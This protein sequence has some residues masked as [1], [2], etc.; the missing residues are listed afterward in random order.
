V[1]LVAAMPASVISTVVDKVKSLV[2]AGGPGG[3]GQIPQGWENQWRILHD[4]SPP[5]S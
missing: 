1:R 4:S 5:R 2:G 3:G